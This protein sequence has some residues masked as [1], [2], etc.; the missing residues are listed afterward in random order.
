V[1]LRRGDQ[2]FHSS[3]GR[4]EVKLL[5]DGG[6]SARV[7]FQR[8]PT[9]PYI[10][11][12]EQLQAN[13]PSEAPV[14]KKRGAPPPAAKERAT[15]RSS[16][17]CPSAAPRSPLSGKEKAAKRSA[18][19]RGTG[20]TVS[21]TEANPPGPVP[22]RL[23]PASSAATELA[24]T[25]LFADGAAAS[26]LSVP[27]LRQLFEAL[28]MGVVP[29]RLLP[30]YTIGRDREIARLRALLQQRRGLLL[31]EGQYGAGK[32]HMI[33]LAQ[34]EALTGNWLTSRLAFD[35]VELPPSNPR[36]IYREIIHNLSYPPQGLIQGLTPLFSRLMASREHRTVQHPHFHRYLSP[37]LY[38]VAEGNAEVAEL[39]LAFIEARAEVHPDDVNR[40]LRANGYRGPRV[41]ALPD[42]RTFGQV[43]TYLLG[44]IATWAQDAG[45]S[46]LALFFDEAEAIDG[47]E[48][49]SR[50]CADTLLRYLAAAT[51]PEAELAFKVEEL[52]RGGHLSHRNLPHLFQPQ[53]PL[54][55]FF[56]FTPL[57]RISTS[58]MAVCGD[59]ERIIELNPLTINVLPQLIARIVSLYQQYRG[60]P[61]LDPEALPQLMQHLLWADRQ[62]L[63]P[64]ARAVSRTIVEYL[65]LVTLR[66]QAAKQALKSSP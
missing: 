18:S 57:G 63:L 11:P 20:P 36:R 10:I 16:T 66:P 62:G 48:H 5:V 56:A 65:D 41:L 49:G 33:E 25:E 29:P 35:P 61:I 9:I 50:Q 15:S 21:Q 14:E 64:H 54:C 12:L 52:Y 42:W 7:V 1:T 59:R 8:T 17:T 38:A 47:L 27:D 40:L 34:G 3:L 4:G 55:V 51:L 39:V 23:A 13:A 37:A 60:R 28:R 32:S 19:P 24:V 53:Q 22:P 46:G 58:V 30:H 26:P 45:Y 44:G 6:R 43:F 31:L 2:V